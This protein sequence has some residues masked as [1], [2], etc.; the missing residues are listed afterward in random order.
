MALFVRHRFIAVAL[1]LVVLAGCGAAR[2][3]PTGTPTGTSSV[4]PGSSATEPKIDTCADSALATKNYPVNRR[5]LTYGSDAR[6]ND[7]HAGPDLVA[8]VGDNGACGFVYADDLNEPAP[9]S[10]R[11]A[12]AWQRK[13]LREG[14]PSLPVYDLECA[15]VIDEFTLVLGQASRD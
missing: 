9:T 12:R 1:A 7:R 5:G 10:P 15:A 8:V 4:E 2:N 13:L 11:E 14:P 3:T 6:A